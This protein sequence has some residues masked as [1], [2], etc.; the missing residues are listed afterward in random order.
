MRF[1]HT[2]P[3]SPDEQRPFQLLPLLFLQF[4]SFGAT[5]KR[6]PEVENR[7]WKLAIEEG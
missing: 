3:P 5:E 2:L 1:C 4:V 6:E 7:I